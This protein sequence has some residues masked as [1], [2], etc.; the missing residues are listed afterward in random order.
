MPGFALCTLEIPT[1]SSTL[2]WCPVARLSER[3]V[4]GRI[5]LYSCVGGAGGAGE[6]ELILVHLSIISRIYLLL[7]VHVSGDVLLVPTAVT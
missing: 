1:H 6:R 5:E 2:R 7:L 3:S 4:I